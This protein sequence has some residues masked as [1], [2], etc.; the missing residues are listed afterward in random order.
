MSPSPHNAAP[1]RFSFYVAPGSDRDSRFFEILKGVSLFCNRIIL[2]VRKCRRHIWTF[3]RD[4]IDIGPFLARF[5]GFVR[6]EIAL[7]SC[8]NRILGYKVKVGICRVGAFL[9]VCAIA[10]IA[11][12]I[13][14]LNS[15]FLENLSAKNYTL[16]ISGNFWMFFIKKY[17]FQ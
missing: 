8:R 12:A 5:P 10:Q 17:Q 16:D 6:Q 11:C 9:R 2:Y 4:V 13:L 3:L 14:R 15:I 1:V 7:K